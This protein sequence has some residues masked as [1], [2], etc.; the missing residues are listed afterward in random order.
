M[1]S[2]SNRSRKAKKGHTLWTLARWSYF[3]YTYFHSNLGMYTLGGV[4]SLV[5][6]YIEGYSFW[7]I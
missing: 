4:K 2:I 6:R 7:S 5:S 1:G 3:R